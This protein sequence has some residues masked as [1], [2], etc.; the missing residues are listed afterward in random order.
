MKYSGERRRGDK[1]GGGDEGGS[2]DEIGEDEGGRD[3][4]ILYGVLC[5]DILGTRRHK[6]IIIKDWN[7]FIIVDSLASLAYFAPF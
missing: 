4:L 5:Y 6:I 7:Y 3:V 1:G 2:D